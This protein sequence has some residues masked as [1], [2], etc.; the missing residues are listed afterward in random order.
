MILPGY[1]FSLCAAMD[2]GWSVAVGLGVSEGSGVGV[3]EAVGENGVIVPLNVICV[4]S[5]LVGKE[6]ASIVELPDSDKPQAERVSMITVIAENI[7]TGFVKVLTFST[8][9]F[10]VC[11]ILYWVFAD[12]QP[13][14]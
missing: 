2:I 14:V 4:C 1:V 9:L 8:V 6:V 10:M 7:T 5:T 3:F 13:L 12:M 11:I